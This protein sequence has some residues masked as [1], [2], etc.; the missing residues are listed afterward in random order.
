VM[1]NADPYAYPLVISTIIFLA[2]MVDSLRTDLLDRLER[3][4]IRVEPV[5]E[6]PGRVS[7]G[8]AG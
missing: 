8:V 4:Q 6:R 3:R 7:Q 5:E 1:I 2:V